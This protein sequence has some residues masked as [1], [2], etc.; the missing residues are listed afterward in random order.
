MPFV[1]SAKVLLEELWRLR[2][3]GT[4]CSVKDIKSTGKNGQKTFRN[5]LSSKFARC[6][7][8]REFQA[9]YIQLY[10]FRDASEVAYD[11]GAYLRFIFKT[12]KPHCSFAM[13]KTR[14]ASMKTI[15]LS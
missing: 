10:V 1:V 11:T 8:V 4:K 6:H 2:L 12:K 7:N 9:S 15:S 3:T 13:T 5:L 14:L